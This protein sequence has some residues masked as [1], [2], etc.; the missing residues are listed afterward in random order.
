MRAE[1]DRGR[2]GEG[3]PRNVVS[4]DLHSL[5]LPADILGDIDALATALRGYLVVQ[6]VIDDA[7][8]RR[9]NIYRSAAAAQRA[10]ERARSRGRTAH[11]SLCHLLPIGVISGLG[12]GVR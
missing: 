2:P 8:H 7:G 12:G 4:T 10:V 3:R 6:V 1:I 9:T 5:P 11:V